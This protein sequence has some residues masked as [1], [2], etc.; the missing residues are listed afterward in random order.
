MCPEFT[1]LC[2][3]L[4]RSHA[5]FPLPVRAEVVVVIVKDK[6]I[7]D[8]IEGCVALVLE[9]AFCERLIGKAIRQAAPILFLIQLDN[10]IVLSRA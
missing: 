10:V 5:T 1:G 7:T 9:W 8:S 2:G 3:Q 4:I 6:R